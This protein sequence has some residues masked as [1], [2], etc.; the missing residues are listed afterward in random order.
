M[1]DAK[2]KVLMLQGTAS[3]VGKS[4]LATA[5]CRI[6]RQDGYRVAP[7]KAQNMSN[8][9]FVTVD[10]REVGRAQATQA[11][12]AGVELRAEMNPLLLKPEADHRSQVVLLGRPQGVLHGADF[13]SRKQE[14][15]PVVVRSLDIL[16]HEYDLV[17]IEGAG[18]PA[19]INLRAG[20]IANMRVACHAQAPVLLVGDIDRGG[21]FAHIVGTLQLLEREERERVAGL[22]V[23]KFRGSP[24]L[25]R[26]GIEWLSCYTDLPVA[27][28]V[29]WLER[30]GV[31]DEDAVSLE[32]LV[33]SPAGGLDIVA[34]A[35]PRI[36]NFDDLDP[37]VAEADVTVRFVRQ[38]GE[39]GSPDLVILPGT[40]S[41]IADLVWLRDT[42]LDA[43][44]LHHRQRGGAVIGICGGFQMLGREIRDPAGIESAH[45]R[46][47]GLH[48]LEVRTT[49]APVKSTHR[50]TAEIAAPKGLLAGVT[51][52]VAGYEIHMG[53]TIVSAP[54]LRI[55]V[56]SGTPCEAFDGALSDDG[57]VFGTYLHGIFDNDAL[58]DAIL[59]R[60][61]ERRG[62][63]RRSAS[64]AVWEREHAYDRLAD[65][66]RRAL[67]MDLIRGLVE[68]RP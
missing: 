27:G 28:V 41:T 65:H 22:V 42:G 56:R 11:A 32:A 10:G 67:D 52:A 17:V 60:L 50:V 23:N 35:F 34:I 68:A 44:V 7:F 47:E 4:V 62:L 36:A 16:R 43:A 54:A 66:V 53:E 2:G 63:A 61:A 19:E 40:K 51:G 6:F 37:L 39:F 55:R 9:S 38:A 15:W 8:N 18:S 26:A 45:E 25:L 21:V 12:A 58:R 13:L 57:Q 48:L 5:L 59:S 49:F 20:D 24:E 1:A 46:A 29:P 64:G 14:F 31:A 33:T 30:I 3:S